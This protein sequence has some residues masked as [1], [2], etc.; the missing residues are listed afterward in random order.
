[1]MNSDALMLA[2]IFSGPFILIFGGLATWAGYRLRRRK[3]K[4]DTGRVLLGMTLG[5]CG[6]I[7]L[8]ATICGAAVVGSSPLRLH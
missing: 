3:Y 7:A 5:I 8:G 4:S 6:C 1:M 2:L